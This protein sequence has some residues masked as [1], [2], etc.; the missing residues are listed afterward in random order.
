MFADQLEAGKTKSS[1]HADLLDSARLS[2]AR[3]EVDMGKPC[4]GVCN[5]MP[6]ALTLDLT[7]VVGTPATPALAGMS[8][9]KFGQFHGHDGPG[10]RG[11]DQPF[12]SGRLRQHRRCVLQWGLLPFAQGSSQG[13]RQQCLNLGKG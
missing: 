13:F 10:W 12:R 4:E 7:A 5:A 2:K 9:R 3:L 8:V 11:L 1:H 6:G